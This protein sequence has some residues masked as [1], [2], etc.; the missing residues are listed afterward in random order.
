NLAVERV[1]NHLAYQL[2]QV[3][4]EFKVTAGGGLALFKKLY[5]IKKQYKK[6]QRIYQ[7]TIQIFPQLKYPSLESCP[8]YKESLRYK[9]HLSYMLGEVLIQ[10]FKNLH[11]GAGFKLYKDFKRTHEEFKALKE[12][13][14]EFKEPSIHTLKGISDNKEFFL[15][16]YE[17][18]KEI[19]KTHQNYPAILDNIFYNFSY[20][21]QNFDLIEEWLLSDDFNQRYKKENHPYPSLLNPKKLNDENEEI[22]YKNIAAKLA[23][24]MNL[25]LPENYEFINISPHGSGRSAMENFYTKNKIFYRQ[26]CW[27][28]SGFDRYEY[29]YCSLI[30]NKNSYCIIMISEY[31]FK[32]LSKFFLLIDKKVPVLLVV[33]DP[34][35]AIKCSINGIAFWGKKEIDITLKHKNFDALFGNVCSWRYVR[36]NGTVL[37]EWSPSKTPV[38]ENIKGYFRCGGFENS[39]FF[40]SSI[41]ASLKH[42][43]KEVNF[44]EIKDISKDKI[45]QTMGYF[46]KKFGFNLNENQ[47]SYNQ[48]IYCPITCLLPFV[49]NVNDM[50]IIIT[51]HSKNITKNPNRIKDFYDSDL[52]YEDIYIS[53]DDKEFNLLKKDTTLFLKVKDYIKD[54]ILALEKKIDEIENS[55]INENDVLNYIKKD[56]EL[57]REVKKIFD[58]EYETIKQ[59]RPDIVALWKYYQEFEKMCENEDLSL[60]S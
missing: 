47:H 46:A 20:F 33:R 25:P 19:L 29:N 8:D 50:K 43:T 15:K 2:G 21:I 58:Q 27:A 34:I 40:Q 5:C 56:K 38:L 37:G 32:D 57:M 26:L 28:S 13:L 12:I 10:S 22:N 36:D 7:Q 53:I 4:I 23:W 9:F 11:K 31:H 1:K 16:E 59:H 45:C 18:I 44:I 30:D 41:L 54:F 42:C 39:F 35:S 48:V 14:K 55:K 60:N 17:R 3:M 51:N 6:E 24:D 52:K 49:L